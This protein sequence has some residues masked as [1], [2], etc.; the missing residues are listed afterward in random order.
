MT[1]NPILIKITEE[2][3]FYQVPKKKKHNRRSTDKRRVVKEYM[4]VFVLLLERN[5]T[6][7]VINGTENESKRTSIL[8]VCYNN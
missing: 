4:W 6:I 8:I 1:K 3:F 7:N 2:P 5:E